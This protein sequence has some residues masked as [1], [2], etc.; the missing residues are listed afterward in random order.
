MSIL[1]NLCSAPSLIKESVSKPV[2]ILEYPPTEQPWGVV[3]ID[4]LQLSV[5]SRQDSKYVL[6]MVDHFSKYVIPAPIQ[7]KSAKAVAHAVVTHLI[8]PYSIPRVLL[9]DNEAEFRN[10]VLEVICKQF[11]MKQ[12]FTVTYLPAIVLAIGE[13][14]SGA[15]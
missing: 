7:D 8:C 11:N 9:S 10:S 13:E 6:L 3:V 5:K 12:T 15:G 14:H 1:T 4:L 2:L